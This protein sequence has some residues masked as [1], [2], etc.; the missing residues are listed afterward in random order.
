ME[1]NKDRLLEGERYDWTRYLWI[2]TVS[3][4]F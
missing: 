2:H 1:E 4:I 3:R